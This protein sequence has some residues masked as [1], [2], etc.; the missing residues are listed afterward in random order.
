MEFQGL[1]HKRNCLRG[2]AVLRAVRLFLSA[3][4]LPVQRVDRIIEQVKYFMVAS[5]ERL[6][7]KI[8]ETRG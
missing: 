4:F 8:Q 2:G 1:F 6:L 3:P 7:G 5:F